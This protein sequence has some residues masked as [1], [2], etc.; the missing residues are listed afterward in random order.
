[1]PLAAS[2]RDAVVDA[3]RDGLRAAGFKKRGSVFHRVSADVVHLVAL[4]S[5]ID[6]PGQVPMLTI[7]LAIWCKPL[8]AAGTEPSVIASVWRCRLADVM[9][10]GSEVW[11]PI[12]G[13]DAVPRTAKAI[14][15]ALKAHGV[16]ALD[17]LPDSAALCALWRTGRSPGLG[18]DAVAR[19]LAAM[20][21]QPS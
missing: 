20:E 12:A 5:S 4:Q 2:Y 21:R 6:S 8:A 1:M 9:P 7:N 3:L 18:A 14:L 10:A 17:V 19:Y 11:W 15:G 16:P 13:K